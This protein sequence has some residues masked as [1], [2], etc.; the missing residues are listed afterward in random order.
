MVAVDQTMIWKGVFTEKGKNSFTTLLLKAL[1][2]MVKTQGE[3]QTSTFIP[4]TWLGL[5]NFQITHGT[6]VFI[7]PSS[8]KDI[9]KKYKTEYG[10]SRNA[11]E[12]LKSTP[13][14]LKRGFNSKF[15]FYICASSN[16]W[17]LAYNM[18]TVVAAIKKP[19]KKGLAITDHWT[20]FE[21]YPYFRI[22]LLESAIWPFTGAAGYSLANNM[23]DIGMNSDIKRIKDKYTNLLIQKHFKLEN[24]PARIIHTNP[25][26]GGEPNL[27]APGFDYTASLMV[28]TMK[29][30]ADE[31]NDKRYEKHFH[32]TGF[33]FNSK[34]FLSQIL[35]DLSDD[36]TEFEGIKSLGID[37]LDS[38]NPETIAQ[39]PIKPGRKQKDIGKSSRTYSKT[40][41]KKLVNVLSA[42]ALNKNDSTKFDPI[43]FMAKIEKVAKI[44]FDIIKKEYPDLQLPIRKSAL[45]SDRDTK[46]RI[47]LYKILECLDIYDV[48]NKVTNNKGSNDNNDNSNNS[49]NEDLIDKTALEKAVATLNDVIELQKRMYKW[50]KNNHWKKIPSKTKKEIKSDFFDE[51]QLEKDDLQRNRDGASAAAAKENQKFKVKSRVEKNHS[52]LEMMILVVVNSVLP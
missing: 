47:K 37:N 10:I 9:G 17:N 21:N 35:S 45:I 32:Q 26:D 7:I 41:A 25:R 49:N 13:N 46:T 19:K 42:N 24:D 33:T 4:T 44:L 14:K 28:D 3:R 48:W 52:L 30:I 12:R 39:T 51:R 8:V 18:P 15:N 29:E 31:K 5:L 34:F 20:F 22:P 23:Q 38:L 16:G 43:E 2:G 40:E 11:N 36:L 27:K 1:T 50:Q 6:S